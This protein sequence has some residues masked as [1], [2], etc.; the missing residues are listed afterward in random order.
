MSRFAPQLG[1]YIVDQTC[2]QLGMGS[3][4]FTLFAADKQSMIFLTFPVERTC[5][6]PL[7]LYFL[8]DPSLIIGNAHSLNNSLTHCCLVDLI[9]VT[10][11][12]EDA[13]L[14]LVEVVTVANVDDGNRVAT[15][16]CRCRS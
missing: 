6:S 13:N 3:W 4:G 10:L 9:D 12:C 5:E 16:C 11:A 1:L 15:V 14:K 7:P 2:V 8:S